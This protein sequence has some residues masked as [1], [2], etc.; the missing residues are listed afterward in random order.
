MTAGKLEIAFLGTGTSHGVPMINCDC[1]VC[2]S[3]DPRDKRNRC[4]VAVTT[5]EGKVIL[6]DAPP[7][8][9]LGAIACNLRRVDAVLFT[10]THADHIMGLD[11]IRRFN[12]AANAAIPC[13]T[14]ADAIER[15][16]APFGYTETPWQNVQPHRP[17]LTFNVLNEPTVICGVKVTPIPL[18]HGREWVLGFR[19]GN[20][21]YCTDC[22][23]IP[24]DSWE[25]L[26]GLDLLVLDA[27]RKTPHPTHFNLAGAL[28]VVAGLRP[29]RAL[30]THITHELPHQATC[31]AL[32]PN[33]S[34]AYD[35]LKVVAEGETSPPAIG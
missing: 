16:R 19:M 6:I 9:R 14:S 22:S 20:F 11:D 17:S 1:P 8:L 2:V 18:L 3:S 7:E 30:F 27:L 24:H 35:G 12:E 5:E 32:P 34:L 28:E 23:A 4:A 10:H 26:T 13:H 15:L 31:A 21:A 29:R 25:M 33:I